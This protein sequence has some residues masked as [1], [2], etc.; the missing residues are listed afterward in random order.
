[1]ELLTSFLACIFAFVGGIVGNVVAND[2][3]ISAPRTCTFIIRRAAK[4]LGKHKGRYEEEWLADLS[5]RETVYEKYNH[6]I[7]CYLS[8]DSIRREA[9]KVT[10]YVTYIVPHF[11]PVEMAFNLNS[12]I[13]APL[14]FAAIDSKYR[15][16]RN[17][18][19][20]VGALYFMA[21]FVMGVKTKHPDH[22]AQFLKFA[23][24]STNDKSIA[25]W[26]FEARVTK[27]GR[28]HDFTEIGNSVAKQPSL[29]KF[30]YDRMREK[31][32]IER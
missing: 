25:N 20:T 29:L 8:A 14:W 13:F 17:S 2:L 32:V 16:V 22:M 27:Y 18:G 21:R 11:G 23:T 26:P 30:V 31:K 28:I 4:R 19:W 9:R 15:F 5:E 12:R 24:A 1:M 6:A 10:L 7:G 3:Y